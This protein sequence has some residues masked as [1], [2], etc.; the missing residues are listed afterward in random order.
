ML[1]ALRGLAIV[2]V[3]VGHANLGILQSGITYSES[4]FFRNLHVVLYSLHLPLLAFLFGINISFS[5]R[6]GRNSQ[7]LIRRIVEFFYLYLV[8][9][10]IQGV[11]EILGSRFANTPVTWQEVVNIFKPLGH[12]WF[13]PWVAIAYA[14]IATL[15][16][17]H[18]ICRAMLTLLGSGVLAWFFWGVNGEYFYLQGL[19]LIFFAVG[20]SVFGNIIIK[21]SGFNLLSISFATFATLVCFWIFFQG[22]RVTLPT[23]Q[24]VD[25]TAQ[26]VLSGIL[27]SIFGMLAVFLIFSIIYQKINFRILETVGYYSLPIYLAHLLFVPPVRV[28]LSKIGMSD[29]MVLVCASTLG[30]VL[31]FLYVFFSKNAFLR[32]TISMPSPCRNMIK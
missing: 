16:P 14:A 29:I 7:K 30:L 19:S 17:W 15:Q 32:W 13:L 10:L 9:T 4:L 5:F 23:L 6:A 12:L 27:F 3:V 24:D 28:L 18:N 1:D 11:Y 20:G 22:V 21:N 31:S 2:G 8:W 25:K 26:S